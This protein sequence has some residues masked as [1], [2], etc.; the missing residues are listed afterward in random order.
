MHELCTASG[1]EKASAALCKKK[2]KK[3]YYKW[4]SSAAWKL[5]SGQN[6]VNKS[7]T[8]LP[9]LIA[10]ESVMGTCHMKE[11]SEAE[12]LPLLVRMWRVKSA[13]ESSTTTVRNAAYL[14]LLP[15]GW[16]WLVCIRDPPYWLFDYRNSHQPGIYL[17][18]FIYIFLKV[19]SLNDSG[20]P[21]LWLLN[22]SH[23][24]INKTK[25]RKVKQHRRNLIA[26]W[27][28][29][30]AKSWNCSGEG[31]WMQSSVRVCIVTTAWPQMARCIVVSGTI[32]RWGI[33][34]SPFV[35]YL[36]HWKIA[37][38]G[39]PRPF[40]WQNILPKKYLKNNK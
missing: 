10:V 30:S 14:L 15:Q 25:H 12:E 23:A 18:L 33:V 40:F 2:P 7:A 36:C 38:M 11:C 35:F 5:P 16:W 1:L 9:Q 26:S 22:Y 19:L 24:A 29:N 37:Q 17:F 28:C 31:V 8:R 6:I 32:Y 39:N 27:N 20:C 4:I 34:G 3:Q 13:Q 21:M